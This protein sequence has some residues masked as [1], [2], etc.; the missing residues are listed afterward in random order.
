DSVTVYEQAGPMAAMAAPD[1]ASAAWSP[2][3]AEAAEDLVVRLENTFGRLT[4]PA[5]VRTA[6]HGSAESAFAGALR[7]V[8]TQRGY[9]LAA[10]QGASPF[11]FDYT[12]GS[13]RFADDS[14]RMITLVL[15]SMSQQVAEESGIYDLAP[16]PSAMSPS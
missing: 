4:E 9:R 6:A 7:D 11:M 12:I 13:A 3:L 1:A 16:S 14:R 15:Y 5:F 8:L 2:G 10:V